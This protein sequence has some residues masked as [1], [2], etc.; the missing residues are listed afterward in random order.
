MRAKRAR[1]VKATR[2]VRRSVA[3]SRELVEEALAAAPPELAHN[4]NRLVATAL[5]EYAARQKRRAV[6]QAV[7]RMAADPAI[8]AEC[9]TIAQ[10]FATTE[11]DGLRRD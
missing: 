3:L 8:R 7:A 9:A 11:G 2:T 1:T 6:E 4:L 5:R 10:D